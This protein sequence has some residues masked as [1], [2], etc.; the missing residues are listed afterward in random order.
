M[1]LDL[2]EVRPKINKMKIVIIVLIGTIM[3]VG[4]SFLGIYVAKQNHNKKAQKQILINTIKAA[5]N[6]DR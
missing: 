1:K 6:D 3:L 4:C 2:I 5:I